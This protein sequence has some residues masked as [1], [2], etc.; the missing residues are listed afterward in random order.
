MSLSGTA[1]L[2]A[3]LGC[4]IV[5]FVYNFPGLVAVKPFGCTQ[6]QRRATTARH[7]DCRDGFRQAVWAGNALSDMKLWTTHTYIY[8]YIYIHCIGIYFVYI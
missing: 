5:L 1:L 6:K 7:R 2:V 3:V 8:I 4:N